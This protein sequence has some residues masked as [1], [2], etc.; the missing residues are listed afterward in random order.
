MSWRSGRRLPEADAEVLAL[1]QD[2]TI[3][4]EAFLRSLTAALDG[5]AYCLDGEV[6][7]P[8]DAEGWRIVLAPI[9]DLALGA[10]S[11]PRQH[12]EIYFAGYSGEQKERFL[13]RFELAFRR[14]GG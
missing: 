9:A 7:R 3:S 4:R 13:Q 14:A 10:L 6:I 5:A 11:M 12:V 8:V 1:V 2:M